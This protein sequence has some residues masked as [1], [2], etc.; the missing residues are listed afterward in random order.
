VLSGTV[1]NVVMLLTGEVA[2]CAG[3]SQELL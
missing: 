1:G 3:S 2:D